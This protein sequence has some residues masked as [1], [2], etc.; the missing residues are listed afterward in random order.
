MKNQFMC[1]PQ[2]LGFSNTMN[3]V[4]RSH[5]STM[6][7]AKN[8]PTYWSA[9]DVVGYFNDQKL[10]K[11]NFVK[12]KN[13]EKTGKAILHYR[14]EKEAESVIKGNNGRLVNDQRIQLE[15][16]Q[17]NLVQKHADKPFKGKGFQ[18]WIARR[19]YIQNLSSDVTRDDIYALTKD[20]SEI[21]EITFPRSKEGENLGFS[22][23]YLSDSSQISNCVNSL[24]GK[25]VFGKPLQVSTSLKLQK[26]GE[27]SKLSSKIQYV[28][29]L[30]RKYA[31]RLVDTIY[32]FEQIP[33]LKLFVGNKLEKAINESERKKEFS[34][35]M[36]FEDD[37]LEKYTELAI[38]QYKRFM[39]E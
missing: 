27:D 28:K 1:N 25:E 38:L 29:Y 23:V 37:T 5:I 8:L 9:S 24:H 30:K 10:N 19:V 16:Y 33:T 35:L 26:I 34:K 14:F 31:A 11:I 4:S 13:G 32:D 39:F 17:G 15:L 22:I 21:K 36:S 2:N 12:N 7:I 3:M 20:L 18:G 6:V